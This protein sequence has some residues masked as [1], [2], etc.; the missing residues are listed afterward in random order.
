[1]QSVSLRLVQ[2]YRPPACA[3]R[4]SGVAHARAGAPG[5]RAAR[6]F[7]GP[8]CLR[9]RAARS[10]RP[11]LAAPQLGPCASAGSGRLGPGSGRLRAAHHSQGEASSLA[12]QPLPRVLELAASEAADVAA[13]G[14]S[15]PERWPRSVG[16]LLCWRAPQPEPASDAVRRLEAHVRLPAKRLALDRVQQVGP[17]PGPGLSWPQALISSLASLAPKAPAVA[18]CGAQGAPR[19]RPSASAHGAGLRP[20]H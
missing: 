14:H 16:L 1:M 8:R 10:K 9:S 4:P 20:H 15:G 18:A 2:R 13:S 7:Q 6:W 5:H 19:G 12:A 3:S 11:S 17:R